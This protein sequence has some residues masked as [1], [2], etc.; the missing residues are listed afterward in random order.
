M[1][2]YV[3]VSLVFGKKKGKGGKKENCI[4]NSGVLM[5]IW[6]LYILSNICATI[7]WIGVKIC[8]FWIR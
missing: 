7:Y 2:N 5:C 4:I 8:I 1:S 6:S 3:K